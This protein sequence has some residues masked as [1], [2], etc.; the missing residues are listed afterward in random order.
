MSRQSIN[1]PGLSHLTG[2]PVASRIGP[3]LVSSIITPFRPGTRTASGDPLEQFAQIFEH[4]KSMLDAA[5]AT[6]DDVAKINFW[7]SD[8]AHR[9]LVEP[10]WI[11]LFP[12]PNSR[13]ARHTQL[14]TDA[15]F[16]TGD[17]LAYITQ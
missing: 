11:K 3:L 17:F 5:G 14:A 15:Q 8:L 10:L 12:D 9:Q 6:W 4:M 13:P 7:V 1:I 2:I 16:I